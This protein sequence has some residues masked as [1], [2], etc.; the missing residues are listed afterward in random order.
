VSAPSTG[1]PV[2]CVRR[3]RWRF[4]AKWR[5]G[6]AAAQTRNLTLLSV[7]TGVP[8]G[9][10]EHNA[11]LLHLVVEALCWRLAAD[12]LAKRRPRRGDGAAYKT[13]RGE[14]DRLEAKRMRLA[15]LA[16]EAVSAL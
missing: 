15:E 9:L 10:V 6:T 16:T 8:L 13:W 11:A 12:D 14:Q 2:P 1:I 3:P 5:R 4:V 7:G